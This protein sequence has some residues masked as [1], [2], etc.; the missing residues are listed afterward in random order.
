MPGRMTTKAFALNGMQY[1]FP[2]RPSTPP[3]NLSL[4]DTISSPTYMMS[5]YSSS[6]DS[7]TP[8]LPYRSTPGGMILRIPELLWG[9]PYMQLSFPRKLRVLELF[10]Q[11]AMHVR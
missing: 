5:I 9:T 10:R 2:S 4:H 7:A 1:I 3:S 6:F 11:N 8:F